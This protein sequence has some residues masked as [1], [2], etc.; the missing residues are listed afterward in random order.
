MASGA[1]FSFCGK[2]PPP[3]ANSCSKKVFFF[4]FF[5][6]FRPFG[7]PCKL[8]E[9][10]TPLG[11]MSGG[12]WKSLRFWEALG[13]TVFLWERLFFLDVFVCFS[14]G[15]WAFSFLGVCI[16]AF[17]PFGFERSCFSLE[18][19]SGLCG[20]CGVGLLEGL[21]FFEWF[22]SDLLEFV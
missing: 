20:L 19:L 8:Q 15:S 17:R 7:K 2:R 13:S 3:T 11:E 1:G 5:F 16:Y 22:A 14:K 9:G 12:G 18:W 4:F 6:F 10:A 21:S